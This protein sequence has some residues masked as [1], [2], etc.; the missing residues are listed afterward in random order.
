MKRTIQLLLLAVLTSLFSGLVQAQWSTDPNVNTLVCNEAENQREPFIIT[1]GNGGAIISWRDYRY[2]NSM[3]GGDIIAQ[4]LD[5]DGTALWTVNGISVNAAELGKGYFSPVMVE[6]GYGGAVIGW[7]RTPGSLYNYD[8]FA[9]KVNNDGERKWALNDVIVSDR[10]GTESFHQIVSDDSCGAILTWT[11]LPGTPGSTDIY[12]Q[13]VD[14]AGTTKWTDDGVEICMAAESQSNPQITGDGNSGAI[15]TWGDSRKAVGES[16]I[17]AQRISHDGTVLWT[18]DGVEVCNYLYFQD[19][20]VIIGD[21]DGGAIIAWQDTRSGNYD[22]YA[23]RIN[24]EGEFQWTEHGIPVCSAAQNQQSAAIVSDGEGGAII[25]WQ[26]ERNGTHDIYAQRLNGSGEMLWAANGVAVTTATN[27]QSEPVAISDNAGGI[28][29]TWWDYRSDQFADIYA[30][31]ITASGTPVWNNN[32]TAVC[33]APGYQEFPALASDGDEGAI[34]VWADMRNGTDYDIYAQ[35]IDKA[36]FVGVFVD[37]DLDG[38]GDEEEQGPDGNKPDYDGNS[39]GQPDCQQANVASFKS[40]D[41]QQYVT[42]AVPEDV[43]L[44]NVQAIGNPDPGALNSPEEG[45][46]PYGFFSFT[47]TGLN[48]GGSTLATFYLHEGPEIDTYYK[49]GPTPTESTGW[50][51]FEY[52][53]ETGAEIYQDTILLWLTDGLR[54]DYDISANGIIVEPGGPVLTPTSIENEELTIFRLEPNYP[55]PFNGHT[56]IE[57]SIS[58]NMDITIEVFDLTGR[59]VCTL[60]DETLPEGRHVIRWVASRFH[61]GIYILKMSAGTQSLTRKMIKTR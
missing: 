21:G 27:N 41:N 14:S 19:S 5:T 54:G 6:D 55:N 25:V 40:F 51:E 20:P 50:Y 26:D 32:G 16:D 43:N 24:A 23:Q 60:L 44:E 42:L 58:Y 11:H 38:I 31:K 49:Y 10:S 34:I 18:S 56:N 22:I 13:R 2:N 47:I 15:I 35:L 29:I 37:D 39:D 3:F 57:F 61:N 45:T 17:Y 53:G 12:A 7:G 28:I 30:Q 36:G 8:I 52:D 46:Y 33:T 59:L 9:Q 4:R 48:P 1:D